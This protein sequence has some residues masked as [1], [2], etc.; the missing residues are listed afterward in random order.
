MKKFLA[1]FTA[2]LLIEPATTL[3]AYLTEWA[4]STISIKITENNVKIKNLDPPSEEENQTR[5]IGF[6]IPTDSEGDYED[7]E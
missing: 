1:G 6:Q 5:V 4:K 3:I 7:E 2:A